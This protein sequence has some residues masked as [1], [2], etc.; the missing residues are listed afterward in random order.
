MT[1]IDYDRTDRILNEYTYDV[2]T[3][4]MFEINDEAPKHTALS[5]P[6]IN[7]FTGEKWI[8]IPLKIM[9]RFP[10]IHTKYMDDKIPFDMTLILCPY[11]LRTTSMKG[12]F[13]FNRY[14]DGVMTLINTKNEIIRLDIGLKIDD[15]K[16]ILLNKRYQVKIKTL[17]NSLIEL[18]DCSYIHLTQYSSLKPLIS[19]EYYTNDLNINDIHIPNV[20]KAP[21]HP[22]TLVHII[23]YLSQSGQNKETIVVGLDAT[24]RSVT[25]FDTKTSGFDAYVA[26][27]YDKIIDRHGYIIPILWLHAKNMYP[28]AKIVYL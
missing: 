10:I 1:S 27:F 19:I 4:S 13:I 20:I 26:K 18:Q 22:K 5:D 24:S 9:L 11:T 16:N 15:D 7:F 23:Q 2:L 8:L 6:V 17:R 3:D 14:V 25:G 28:D 12:K 21:F